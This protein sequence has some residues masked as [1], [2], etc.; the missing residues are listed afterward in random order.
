MS[1]SLRGDGE[2]LPSTVNCKTDLST[3]NDILKSKIDVETRILTLQKRSEC[4]LSLGDIEHAIEDAME[5]IKYSPD[6]TEGYMLHGK[7]LTKANRFEDALMAFRRGLE[8]DPNDKVITESLRE[9][10]KT[11]VSSYEKKE[12]GK[13]MSYNAVNLCSQ[14]PYPGDDELAEY[15]REIIELKGYSK[16][17]SV[18]CGMPDPDLALK[19]LQLARKE[20]R[21]GNLT[22]ALKSYEVSLEKDPLNFDTWTE[23]A[24]ILQKTERFGEAFQCVSAVPA[25]CRSSDVWKLGG[26]ILSE[27][28][29]PVTAESWLRRATQL[30]QRKDVEAATLFQKIRVHRLYDPLTKG[31]KVR[32]DFTEYGRAVVAKEDVKAGDIIFHD[33]P[34]VFA[35]LLQNMDVLAC[36]NCAKSL[37]SAQDYFGSSVLKKNKT[38]RV[39]VDKYWPRINRVP[40]TGCN[41]ETYCSEKCREEAWSTYHEPLCPSVNSKAHILYDLC[42]TIRE[43][44]KDNDQ[45]IWCGSFSPFM[46]ARIWASIA[47]HAKKL[48]KESGHTVPS[49]AQWALAKTPYRR[50][51]AYGVTG[52]AKSYS[53]IHQVMRDV[54]NAAP[55][56][57]SCDVSMRDFEGRYFQLACNVQCFSDGRNPLHCFLKS[58][59]NQ[60]QYAHLSDLV[61]PDNVPEANFAGVFPVQACFNHSCANLAEVMDGV[62]NGRPGVQIRARFDVK[63]G[64]E[65]FTTYIDTS[66]MRRQRRALLFQGYNFWCNCQ[67]CQFEGDGPEMCANCE[68][69][70]PEGKQFPAC[71][72]CRR[73]WYCSSKCQKTSWKAGHKIICTKFNLGNQS[74][75]AV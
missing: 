51:I 1:K 45:S 66:I 56:G 3:Y 26:S 29:L 52:V 43:R 9:M 65:I 19:Y 25:E 31:T 12:K 7:A 48:A 57:M 53:A 74:R 54:F 44:I 64:N 2:K 34:A 62:S 47:C 11:I 39:A 27:L 40:C 58:I 59:V 18:Y 22:T 20:N 61:D 13:D 70:A 75:P 21:A 32:I 33:Q 73:I 42:K 36:P 14:E 67:R 6:I 69:N 68:A 71:G 72:K 37:M 63:A 4:Y 35:Q 55:D 28:D 10:Q 60:P 49:Q 30:S 24:A 8:I 17:P 23:K 16:L 41:E 15:E 50:F 46:M 5:V 38:L